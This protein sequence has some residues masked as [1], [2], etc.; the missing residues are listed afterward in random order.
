VEGLSGFSD[1]VRVSVAR[2][3]NYTG[4][5]GSEFKVGYNDCYSVAICE[6]LTGTS[7]NLSGNTRDEPS[8]IVKRESSSVYGFEGVTV[9]EFLGAAD[10]HAY[11][12]DPASAAENQ[13]T[14]WS[15]SAI[16][17]ESDDL[18]GSALP[19]VEITGEG[20]P[21]GSFP[22]ATQGQA[23]KL[24]FDRADNQGIFLSHRG[25]SPS[26]YKPGDFLTLTMN[27]Y[28]DLDYTGG[29]TCRRT[30]STRPRT[31]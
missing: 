24:T 8:Q 5:P 1:W 9:D 17:Q 29:G 26:A 23:L 2:H 30:R 14:S 27:L 15:V 11:E 6:M 25:V 13:A 10:A 31:V 18:K 4:E 22:G 19:K 28:V 21:E 16:G 7:T 3:Y 12:A 20:K